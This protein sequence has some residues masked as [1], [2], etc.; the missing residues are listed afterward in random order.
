MRTI[1]VY[2]TDECMTEFVKAT[3][4]IEYTSVE[5]VAHAKYCQRMVEHMIN[6]ALSDKS[7]VILHNGI[8]D[9]EIEVSIKDKQP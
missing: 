7:S 2:I 5:G 9:K 4:N 8:D 3:N 1:T 6:S